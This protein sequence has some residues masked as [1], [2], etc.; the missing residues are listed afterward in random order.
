MFTKWEYLVKDMG[1]SRDQLNRYGSDGWRFVGYI[2]SLYVFERRKPIPPTTWA[3]IV[4]VIVVLMGG[5]WAFLHF[6]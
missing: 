3:L 6:Q 4:P 1:L 2:G 5:L